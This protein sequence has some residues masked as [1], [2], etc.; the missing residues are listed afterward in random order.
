MPL[1]PVSVHL[2]E[3]GVSQPLSARL[4]VYWL[5]PARP[6][7]PLTPALAASC[8]TRY[9]RFVRHGC[10]RPRGIIP[11]SA[12]RPGDRAAEPGSGAGTSLTS[13][14][15]VASCTSWRSWTGRAGRCCRGGCP[16]PLT[17]RSALEGGADALRTDQRSSIPIRAANSPAPPSL[18]RSLMLAS[19]SGWARPIDGQRVHRTAVAPAQ[20][21][22]HLSERLGRG[23]AMGTAAS[24]HGLPSKYRTPTSGARP[25]PADGG[26]APTA[27]P[28]DSERRLWA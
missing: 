7:S 15:A 27:A 5:R 21:R 10:S 23:A 14:S 3:H 25:P 20:A 22:G 24:H 28:M 16:T 8:G 11:V 13:P 17:P 19:A 4:I 1:R 9:R 12:A 6:V 2:N 26:L 18:A